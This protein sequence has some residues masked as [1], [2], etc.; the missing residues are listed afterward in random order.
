MPGGRPGTCPAA[1]LALSLWAVAGGAPAAQLS[2][3]PMLGHVT[4]RTA[5]IWLQADGPGQAQ[6]EYWPEQDAAQRRLSAPRPLTEVE[7]FSAR[8]ELTGLAPDTRY[9]YAVLLDGQRASGTEAFP[10]RTLPAWKWRGQPADF[11]VYMGSCAY[12]NDPDW[13]R[14]GKPYGAGEEI[15]GAIARS[16]AHQPQPSLMLWLGD[17]LYFRETDLESPWAMNARYRMIRAHPA[18]GPLLSAAPNYALWDDHDYGPN[19]GN[20]A[21]EFKD[22]SAR[23]FRRYWANP[24]YGLEDLPGVFTRF[25]LFDVEFFLLDDRTY[26]A[27]DTTVEPDNEISWWQEFKNWAIGSN[28]WTRLLGR[29]YMGGGPLWLGENKTLFGP[30]QLD[31]LKQAL[32]GSTATFKVV[33]SGSQLFNDANRFE[34]WQNFKGEREAFVE[35]LERQKIDGVLF[36][37][38]DRHHT[39]LIKRERKKAYPLYELTCSPL[40]AGAGV[41]DAERDNAQRVEGTLVGQRNFCSLE[42]SGPPDGR[43]LTFRSHDSQGRLLW[44]RQLSA[45]ELSMPEGEKP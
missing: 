6:I 28:Q 37:S 39:E 14:P 24:G 22:T 40:S 34:G 16:A 36:L 42:V 38:G 26:R 23:L 1:L 29:R 3:G 4:G 8:I 35:W 19:N 18:L 33:A 45:R 44:E 9:R 5:G 15:F 17:N 20:R 7:D 10:L 12:L 43:Q 30:A 21:F 13:D 11:T 25:S 27:S 31:W 32:I 2:G 41:P